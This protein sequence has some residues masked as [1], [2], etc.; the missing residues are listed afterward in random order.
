MTSARAIDEA[1][2]KKLYDFNTAF[3]DSAVGSKRKADMSAAEKW[4]GEELCIMLQP[5]Y[6]IV[7]LC[8]LRF[9]EALWIQWSWIELE[10]IQNPSGKWIHQIKLM[11]P[12]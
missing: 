7:F 11:L 10:K 1:T 6:L 12:F 8:L 3:V 4:G 5:L 9:D 2:L